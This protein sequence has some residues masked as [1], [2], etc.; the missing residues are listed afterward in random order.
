MTV[1]TV[2][3]ADTVIDPS[4][5]Q[6]GLAGVVLSVLFSF[7]WVVYKREVHRA[8]AAEEKYDKLS[9]LVRDRYVPGLEASTA[10]LRES[11][12]LVLILRDEMRELRS[13]VERP[14]RR[15]DRP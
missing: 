6:F 10:G 14:R 8:D 11:T 4:L 1:W 15:S 2:N 3:L 13:Q 12:E 9:E 7:G 5:T